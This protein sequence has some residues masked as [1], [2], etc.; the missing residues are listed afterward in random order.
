MTR[1]II[2]LLSQL[3]WEMPKAKNKLQIKNSRKVWNEVNAE[4]YKYDFNLDN[5]NNNNNNKT[6]CKCEY[7]KASKTLQSPGAIKWICNSKKSQ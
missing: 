5:N 2:V 3:S 6:Y 4:T 7:R 1:Y